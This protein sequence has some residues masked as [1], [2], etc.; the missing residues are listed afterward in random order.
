MYTLKLS[1]IHEE[2]YCGDLPG[3]LQYKK[4]AA[5]L[6]NMDIPQEDSTCPFTHIECTDGIKARL[7]PNTKTAGPHSNWILLMAMERTIDS[8][9]TCIKGVLQNKTTGNIALL[10]C[11]NNK[12][13]F[14]RR[15]HRAIP[16][17]APGWFVGH[18]RMAAPLY[19]WSELK[20]ILQDS[21]PQL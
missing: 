9:I 2:Y 7:L 12:E 1:S 14:T 11:K 18:Y 19:F 8:D 5:L 10:T 13:S 21:T 20:R 16:S 4:D 17:N 3:T 6:A 15:N